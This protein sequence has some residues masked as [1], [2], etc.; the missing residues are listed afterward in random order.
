GQSTAVNALAV[1]TLLA[2]ADIA[3]SMDDPAR[4][5]AWRQRADAIKQAINVYL[6]RPDEGQYLTTIFQDRAYPP[7]PYAQAWALA[8]DIVPEQERQRVAAH[9]LELLS[10]DPNMPNLQIFGMFWLLEG[11]GRA[12][13]TADA[14]AVIKRDYGA[15]LDRGATT[16]WEHFD[17]DR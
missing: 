12:N 7:G 14:I 2:A 4:A 8:Y 15:M 13:R 9:L 3:E 16:W 10:P 11:L 5:L 6:Y 1:G 17:A